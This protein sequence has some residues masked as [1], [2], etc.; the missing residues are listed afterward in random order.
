MGCSV[1]LIWLFFS[2]LSENGI[3]QHQENHNINSN[4]SSLCY[5][6]DTVNKA[7]NCSYHLA[8]EEPLGEDDVIW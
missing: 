3:C 2:D 8:S 1:V 7:A 4:G 6:A 5:C